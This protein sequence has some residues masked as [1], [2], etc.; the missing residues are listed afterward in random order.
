MSVDMPLIDVN[1]SLGNWPF[2]QLRNNTPETMIELMNA[3][4]IDQAWVASFDAVLNREPKTAN[5]ALAEAVAPY[6]D[7]LVPF[8][9][10]NPNFPTWQADM[11]LYLGELGFAGL[12]T[13]PNYFQY[14]LD[15]PCFGELLDCVRERGV[16]LQVAVR[17]ADERM[18]HPLVKVPAV[19]ITKLSMQ[20]DR[21]GGAQIILINTR[22]GEHGIAT[23][24]AKERANVYIETSH[25]EGV[26]GV[27]VLMEKL[28]DDQVLFG[29]HAPL[30]Y[31]ASALLKLREADLSDEQLAK[32]SGRNAQGI[33]P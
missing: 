12:R 14:A 5:L 13:Y 7:R 31:A 32:V 29:T 9:V 22:A 1:A 16:P 33:L 15:A 21:A 2:R 18:H 25:A 30:L 23:K 11:G 26:G 27:A 19:D 10:V 17:V 3:N 8:A 6:R 24:L 20:L 4:G 28:S